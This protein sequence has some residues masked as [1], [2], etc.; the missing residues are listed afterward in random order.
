MVDAPTVAV[1]DASLATSRW[2]QSRDCRM[3]ATS[4]CPYCCRRI[5]CCCLSPSPC[6]YRCYYCW[7]RRGRGRL[8]TRQFLLWWA[9]RQLQRRR[10]PSTRGPKVERGGLTLGH[11]VVQLDLH[12]FEVIA[13]G[14]E[15][16]ERL[17][18]LDK[19]FHVIEPLV[20]SL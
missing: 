17:R 5:R 14:V 4:G 20:Q 18:S 1:E 8:R 12:E 13:N 19:D 6:I 10:V 11:R 2:C 9:W 16:G 15:E 3:R 7:G